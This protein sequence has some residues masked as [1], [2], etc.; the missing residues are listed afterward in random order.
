MQSKLAEEDIEAAEQARIN[1]DK[2]KRY[3]IKHSEKVREY[4]RR[5]KEVHREEHKTY[6]KEYRKRIF[7]SMSDVEIAERA[8]EISDRNRIYCMNNREK[9]LLLGKAYRDSHKKERRIYDKTINRP[10][11]KRRGRERR[12]CTTLNG[13]SITI[14]GL[15]KRPYPE[16]SKCELCNKE[17]RRLGYHHWENTEELLMHISSDKNPIFLKGIWICQPCNN[18]VHRL[19]EFPFLAEA[20]FALKGMIDKEVDIYIQ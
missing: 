1:C 7:A 9:K 17:K 4:N 2:S 11:Q 20:W 8:R 15:L 10:K 13:K 19:T 16:D 3:C 12:L 5:Y 14:G 6:C 18:F